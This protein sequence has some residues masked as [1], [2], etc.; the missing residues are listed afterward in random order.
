MPYYL[1][2]KSFRNL[3]GSVSTAAVNNDDAFH[4]TFYGA[5]ATFYVCF[6]ILS[7]DYYGSICHRLS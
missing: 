1:H 2:P 5:D 7:E 3:N 6:L 4:P